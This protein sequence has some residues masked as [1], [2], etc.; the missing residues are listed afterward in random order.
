MTEI[1]T[2]KMSSKGQVIIPEAIRK[3]MNL[4]PGDRFV[5][6]GASE[7]VILKTIT[8]PNMD[9]F[10]D[11]IAEARRQARRVG[12]KRSDIAE[13]VRAARAKK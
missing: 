2:T 4:K 10:E 13:A 8:P 12:L 3:K 1:A 9:Q 5:V 7:T 11:L 6:V